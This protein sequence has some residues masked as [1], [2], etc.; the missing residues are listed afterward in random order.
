ML[1]PTDHLHHLSEFLHHKRWVWVEG[2]ALGVP[3]W[4][5]VTHD[6][7]KLLPDE[8]LASVRFARGQRAL[9]PTGKDAS[10]RALERHHRRNRH[11]PQA[12]LVA[13]EPAPMSDACRREMLA[14]WRAVGHRQESMSTRAWYV[15]NRHRLPLHPETRAW[16]ERELRVVDEEASE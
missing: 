5:L 11:H 12:W 7:S 1:R 4:N 10:R 2:R 15:A 3:V 16:V 14:D 8:W 13:G 9:S 6:L